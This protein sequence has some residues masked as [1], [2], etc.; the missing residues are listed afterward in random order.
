MRG[1]IFKFAAGVVMTALGFKYSPDA[2]IWDF[3]ICAGVFVMVWTAGGWILDVVEAKNRGR[4]TT[5]AIL[6]VILAVIAAYIYIPEY[7]DLPG[8]SSFVFVRLYDSPEPRPKY[9]FDFV[10][11]IGSGASAYLSPSDVFIFSVTDAHNQSYDLEVPLSDNAIPIDR[12]IFL[13][14]DAGVSA[15]HTTLRV[16]VNGKIVRMRVLDV[17]LDFGVDYW[18]WKHATLLTDRDGKNN[19]AFTVAMWGSGHTTLSIAAIKRIELGFNQYL[20]NINS[21]IRPRGSD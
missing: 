3:I 11:P 20:I 18:K 10:S 7:R 16:I 1:R 17:P 6:S 4:V 19:A 5:Y 9:L 2:A 12:Y 14:C 8:F 15:Q 13:L 21:P